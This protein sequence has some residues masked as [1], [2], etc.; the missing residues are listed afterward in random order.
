MDARHV[1][2]MNGYESLANNV[3]KMLLL[4]QNLRTKMGCSATGATQGCAGWADASKCGCCLSED[5]QSLTNP[6]AIV[7]IY[8]HNQNK[9]L[10][11]REPFY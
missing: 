3:P 5:Y 4:L 2:F 9:Q 8:S 10:S 11:C 7:D 1:K 6:S